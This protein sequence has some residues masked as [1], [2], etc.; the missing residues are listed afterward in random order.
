MTKRIR[1]AAVL[2]AA[3]LLP[4][5]TAGLQRPEVELEG[6]QLGSVGLTGGTLL[7]N[8]RVQNPNTFTLRGEDLKYELYLRK[9][10]GANGVAATGDSAWTRI[11]EG[12]YDEKLE[13]GGRSTET[14]Q[15]PIQFSFSDLGGA[16]SSIIRTGRVDYRAVGTID[17][18]TPFG[19]R[20]VPFRKTGT[21]MMSGTR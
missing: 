1:Y 13:I 21:F 7:A 14:F 18:R 5:C 6:V 10:V 11:A 12:T 20:N 9:P 19:N 4:A 16:A 8:V 15:V 3:A 2:L 17:V